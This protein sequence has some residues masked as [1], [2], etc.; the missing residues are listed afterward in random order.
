MTGGELA[1]LIGFV[2]LTVAIMISNWRLTNTIRMQSKL[3]ASRSFS[4]Y[5]LAEA[6]VAKA[7][8]ERKPIDDGSYAA[9]WETEDI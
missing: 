4:E 2:V 7:N 5:S 3:L 6:R 1:F 8:D 9:T